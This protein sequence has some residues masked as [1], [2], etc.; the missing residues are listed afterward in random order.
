VGLAVAGLWLLVFQLPM[1]IDRAQLRALETERLR[2]EA[3]LSRVRVHLHPHFLLNTLNAIAG[4]VT[5]DAAEARRLIAALGDLVRDA[6]SDGDEPRPF[7]AEVAWLRRYA[8]ILEARHRGLISFRWE[9]AEETLAALVPRLLL[10]P[11]VENA[12]THGALRKRD[13]GSVCV[14]SEANYGG[15]VRFVIEDEWPAR[16]YLV[17]LLQESGLAE[18]VAAVATLDEAREALGPDGITV[19]V[20]FVDVQLAGAARDGAGLELVRSMAGVSGAPLFVLA[21]A[22]DTHAVKAFDLGVV[23]Y[24]LKPFSRERVDQCLARVRGRLARIRPVAR[25]ARVVA[26]RKSGLV[27]FQLEEVW[28]FEAAD[29]LTFVHTAHGRFDV[30]LSLS[31]IEASFGRT[32]LSVHRRWLI[33]VDHVRMLERESGE[34]EL[35][36]GSGLGREQQGMRVPV[37]RERSQAVRALLLAGTTGLRRR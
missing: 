7:A 27:F 33:N 29:R 8:E 15:T 26:R 28:G 6:L 30:D 13:G 1:L 31:A 35:L 10:Q 34:Y 23:D 24:L 21:T 9:L 20:A 32:L 14:R 12:V 17:E 11:L 25:N 22:F 2:S 4:L 5:E 19:D 16:N 37:A 3:E 18:V 36:V